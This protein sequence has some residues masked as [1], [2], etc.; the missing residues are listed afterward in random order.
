MSKCDVG[1]SVLVVL[2]NWWDHA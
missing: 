2:L 1:F